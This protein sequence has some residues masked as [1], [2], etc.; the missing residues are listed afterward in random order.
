MQCAIGLSI[1]Y[2]FVYSVAFP[3]DASGKGGRAAERQRRQSGRA[4]YDAMTLEKSG[5]YVKGVCPICKEKS[6]KATLMEISE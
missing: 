2:I 5:K 4:D 1:Q 6:P 3:A